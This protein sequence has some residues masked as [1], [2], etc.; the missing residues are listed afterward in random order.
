M[1]YGLAQPGGSAVGIF[2]PWK[3]NALKPVKHP[4]LPLLSFTVVYLAR[5]TDAPIS[6]SLLPL[7]IQLFVSSISLVPRQYIPTAL[8]PPLAYYGCHYF[9]SAETKH[10]RSLAARDLPPQLAWTMETRETATLDASRR[11]RQ[12][13]GAA[14]DEVADYIQSVRKCLLNRS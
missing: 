14:A 2:L 10:A 3:P 9:P 7:S 8:P 11:S 5:T 13:A 1:K 4:R 6:P 12:D